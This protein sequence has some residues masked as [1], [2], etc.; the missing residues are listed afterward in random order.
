MDSA[1][2]SPKPHP[3]IHWSFWPKSLLH[4]SQHGGQHTLESA[5]TQGPFPI[6]GY[7]KNSLNPSA[8]C[9]LSWH[10]HLA[11]LQP[12]AATAQNQDTAAHTTSNGAPQSSL[13]CF[14]I[15][16][17]E[18]I[19]GKTLWHLDL[20]ERIKVFLWKCL[21]GILAVKLRKDYLPAYITVRPFFFLGKDTFRPFV[22]CARLWKKQ[23][24]TSSCN[25][26]SQLRFGMAPFS[27]TCRYPLLR[28]LSLRTTGFWIGLSPTSFPM[29]IYMENFE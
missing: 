21:K 23:L 15:C 10:P 24:N 16:T 26:Q 12:L 4:P 8:F 18:L 1:L 19:F 11:L 29:Y 6:L 14:H 3:S 25:V 2:S 20:P 27:W 28:F 7:P 9:A 5:E 22:P 13:L 17:R